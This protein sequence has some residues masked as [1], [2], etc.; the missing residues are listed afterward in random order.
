V[1]IVEDQPGTRE[2]LIDATSEVLASYKLYQAETCEQAMSVFSK[3]CIDL[4]II[5]VNLPDGSGLALLKS[6]KYQQPNACFTMVITDSD[7]QKLFLFLQDRI[8]SD[9]QVE[10]SKQKF[11]RYLHRISNLEP[12]KSLIFD[13]ITRGYLKKPPERNVETDMMLSNREQEVL[14]LIAKAFQRKEIAKLLSISPNTVACHVKNIYS[15]LG[16]SSKAEAVM[17]ALKR[18]LV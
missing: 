7:S 16:I 13:G 9:L 1:I 6:L 2:W 17:E 15:K 8:E 18:D 3:Y 4:A 14:M 11:A 10:D 5:D 12:P